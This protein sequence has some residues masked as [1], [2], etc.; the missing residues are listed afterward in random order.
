MRDMNTEPQIDMGADPDAFPGAVAI[1][2]Y[3]QIGTFTLGL[4][5]EVFARPLPEDDYPGYDV[6][7]VSAEGRSVTAHGGMR[8]SATGSLKDLRRARIIVIPAWRGN[9]ERPPQ[10]LLSELRRAA[11]RGA[12]LVSICDG[13][14]V[15]AHAGLLDGLRATTHWADIPDLKA[16]FPKI[17]TEDDMLY[18][19]EGNILTSAGGASGIDACLHLVR[20]DFG[21][22][23]ANAVARRMVIP[24]HRDGGQRQYVATPIPA[25]AGRTLS[26]TMDWARGQ[27]H[28]PISTKEFAR[29]AAMSERTFLRRFQDE[30]GLSPKTWLTSERMRA[31]QELLERT[32]MPMPEVGQAVGYTSPETFR[33]AFRRIVGVPPSTYRGRFGKVWRSTTDNRY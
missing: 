10:R 9:D 6:T 8:I 31:A 28:M 23:I 15:L 26:M 20:R 16:Q 1:V 17:R 32:N 4:A 29:Q 7:V 13:A 2:I 12:I 14:F 18:V 25:H 24:P 33:A 22:R 19:D 11:Q 5:M 3:D 27:L 21:T 30:V